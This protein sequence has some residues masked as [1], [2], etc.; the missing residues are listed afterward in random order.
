ML[1]CIVFVLYCIVLCYIVSCCIILYCI[2][3]YCIGLYY[4]SRFVEE[5]RST[6]NEPSDRLA[7]ALMSCICLALYKYF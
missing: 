5:I 7:D 2:V 4:K 1:Y 6:G 3:S